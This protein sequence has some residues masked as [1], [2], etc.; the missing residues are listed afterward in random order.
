MTESSTNTEVNSSFR[1]TKHLKLDRTH[2][3]TDTRFL[4]YP[5]DQSS[6][7]VSGPGEIYR[8]NEFYCHLA[9]VGATRFYPK[10]QEHGPL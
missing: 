3:R 10:S 6:S 9:Y 8:R 1:G 2:N 4:L 7:V 5:R